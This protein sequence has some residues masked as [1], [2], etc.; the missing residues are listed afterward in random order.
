MKKVHS[1]VLTEDDVNSIVKEFDEEATVSYEGGIVIVRSP[2]KVAGKPFEADFGELLTN[3][4]PELGL[5]D[6]PVAIYEC[7]NQC[8]ARDAAV[9]VID[10]INRWEVQ[11]FDG[12]LV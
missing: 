7:G 4:H 8:F 2:K 5:G 12:N 1:F 9:V 11:G 10:G 6:Y 3:L